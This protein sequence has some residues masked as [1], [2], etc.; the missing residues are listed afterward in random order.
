M[1]GA[2][3]G[4]I[5]VAVPGLRPSLAQVI[6]A[7]I[8]KPLAGCRGAKIPRHEV[9]EHASHS[10]EGD[11]LRP[12]GEVEGRIGRR[13]CGAPILPRPVNTSAGGAALRNPQV[14]W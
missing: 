3:C 6:L 7:P 9:C 1:G 10:L 5:A 12:V 8:I 11:L 14:R 4:F 13:G 2:G